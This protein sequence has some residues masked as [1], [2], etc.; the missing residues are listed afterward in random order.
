MNDQFTTEA[1]TPVD[2]SLTMARYGH[3]SEMDRS[4]D[5]EYWQR[6]SSAARMAAVWEMVELAHRMKGGDPSELRLQRTV[7]N[8]QRVER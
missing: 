3:L 4:F 5:I 2:T 1:G 8:F 7:V 6:Q